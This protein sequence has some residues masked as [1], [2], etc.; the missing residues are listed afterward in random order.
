MGEKPKDCC[1]DELLL[2]R[3]ILLQLEAASPASL[4]LET[5]AVGLEISALPSDA[6]T[7]S[8][9]LDYLAQKGLVSLSRSRIASAH[10]RAKLTAEGRDFLES[11]SF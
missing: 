2:R 5:L 4:P 10:I 8:A 3:A 7:L 1:V 6:K 11:G 9:A